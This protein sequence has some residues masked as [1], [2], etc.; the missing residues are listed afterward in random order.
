[1]K[2]SIVNLTTNSEKI[3]NNPLSILL[4]D[5]VEFN[6]VL[7]HEYLKD[8]KNIITDAED[9]AVALEKVKNV[10]FDIIL[11]DMQMPIMDGYKATQ[12]IREWEK[13]THQARIPIV[14][15]TA[16]A[17]KEEQEKSL[18]V[19]CDLHLSKPVSKKQLLQVLQQFDHR[20][21]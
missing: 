10:S 8:T 1:V 11:M 20:L 4:V 14:A 6:R 2:D 16:Y 3:N 15:L 9:G 18:S 21:E 7:I 19:G 5:D 17:L 13:L 12:E